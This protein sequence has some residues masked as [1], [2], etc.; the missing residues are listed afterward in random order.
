MLEHW[1]RAT[2]SVGQV[3]EEGGIKRYVTIGSAVLVATDDY[4][5][6]I[7][8]AKHVVFDPSHGYFP[9]LMYVRL[10]KDRPSAEVDLGVQVPLVQDG[11]NLWKSLPDDSDLAV[12]PLPDLSKYPNRHAVSLQDFGGDEDIFQGASVLVLGYPAILGEAYLTT[13]IARGGIIAWTDPDDRINKPFL[14]DANLFSGNSGGPVFRVRNGFDRHGN[15]NLGG[16]FA[17]IGIVSEDAQEPADVIAAAPNFAER[18]TKPHPITG[19]P[20][21]EF[22]IVKNVGGI[23]VIEPVSKARILV[24]QMI[25]PWSDP[26]QPK[27]K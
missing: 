11:K 2:V 26:F 4:H 5:A 20:V 3:V 14:V 10:P 6:C 15:L 7:L 13:P 27:R 9:T 12:V 22:A 16:G 1:R 23:G 8:T 17:F 25:H 19:V 21:P 24:R 18:V